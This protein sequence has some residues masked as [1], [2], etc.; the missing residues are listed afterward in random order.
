MY[1]YKTTGT[2]SKKIRF[3]LEEDK[4]KKVSFEGGCNGNLQGICKLVEGRDAKDVVKMLTGIRCGDKCTS[5][6]DQ[7]A[8]AI[9]QAMEK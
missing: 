8:A 6:P 5:C 2:C 1:H 4:V 7:L 9:K 3:E